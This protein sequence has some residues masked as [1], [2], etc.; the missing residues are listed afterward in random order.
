MKVGG[1]DH[2]P[3]GLPPGKTRYP[4]Y[5]R[6]DGS[7]SRSGR[8]W[9]ISPLPVF[10]PPTVQPVASRYADW[11]IPAHSKSRPSLYNAEK[12]TLHFPWLRYSIVFLSSVTPPPDSVKLS[13]QYWIQ[14]WWFG[15]LIANIHH[16]RNTIIRP[17]LLVQCNCSLIKQRYVGYRKSITIFVVQYQNQ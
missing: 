1:Q 7:E 5:R 10:D 11:A 3:A 4:L 17:K 8:V 14:K 13:I 15:T 16:R 9:K 12:S 2:S 6:L